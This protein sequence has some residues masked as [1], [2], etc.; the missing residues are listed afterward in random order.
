M[1]ARSVWVAC[2]AAA[3]ATGHP[4]SAE[5]EPA[6][7]LP[8]TSGTAVSIPHVPTTNKA[9]LMPPERSADLMA[10]WA[11]RRD[12]IRDRDERRADDEELRV[13]TLREDLAIE[14]L[15]AVGAALV[16]ESRTALEYRW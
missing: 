11:A 3:L 15:F 5:E 10:H 16:R 4:A 8:V 1:R 14:N 7:P 6:P 12:Y 2:A 9:V 13:R